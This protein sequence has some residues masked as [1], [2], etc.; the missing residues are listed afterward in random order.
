MHL[1]L[2]LL[3]CSITVNLRRWFSYFQTRAYSGVH[4]LNAPSHRCR[5]KLKKIISRIDDI[6]VECHLQHSVISVCR[7]IYLRY[8]SKSSTPFTGKAVC[9][10][11]CLSARSPISIV[12]SHISHS[13]LI[14]RHTV[15]TIHCTSLYYFSRGISHKKS[16]NIIIINTRQF[17]FVFS[18]QL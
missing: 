12:S 6:I 9:T 15:P 5:Y 10:W 3:Q 16:S 11:E 13:G 18:E 1:L 7:V 8:L 4:C 2:S 14:I 17:K